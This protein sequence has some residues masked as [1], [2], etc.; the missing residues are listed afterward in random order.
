MDQTTESK[1]KAMYEL[2]TLITVTVNIDPHVP[3]KTS[4]PHLPEQ[5]CPSSVSVAFK[6]RIGTV[7]LSQVLK[8]TL[9]HGN[10]FHSQNFEK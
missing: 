8:P 7:H 4:L 10:Y 2:K 9:G 6:R 1:F 5:T 3:Q